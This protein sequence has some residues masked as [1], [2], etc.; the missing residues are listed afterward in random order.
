MSQPADTVH[1]APLM[2]RNNSYPNIYRALECLAVLP[3]T[4]FEEERRFSQLQLLKTFLRATM[5]EE[6]LVGL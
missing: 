1:Q 4:S 5:G 2:C 6:R 3:A